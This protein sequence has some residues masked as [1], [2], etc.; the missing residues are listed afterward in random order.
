[1]EDEQYEYQKALHE[2][3][4]IQRSE[5]DRF[6]LEIGARYEK[7]LSL[8]AGGALVV[9][10][11]F[12]E[13]IAPSPLLYTRWVILPGW[14][15]LAVGV[16][17]SLIAIYQSQN[18]IQKK[19]ENLDTE[20]SQKLD[21]ENK[22]LQSIESSSNP[23]APKV[24]KANLISLY[25][26]LLGLL[27]LITFAFLNFPTEKP[28]NKNEQTIKIELAATQATGKTPACERRNLCSDKKP[29][30]PTTAEKIQIKETEQNDK[31]AKE[32]DTTPKANGDLEGVIHTESESGEP[33]KT[34]SQG[35]EEEIE[36]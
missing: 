29:S 25:S 35:S 16:I 10:L 6:A 27:F 19:I 18:A 23:H 9:S 31:S 15:L 30:S 24:R 36:G 3:Y 21:P 22:E 8:I 13:K 5:A 12:I 20:I 14:I 17:S 32:T 2:A 34:T 28:K 33:T 1:M 7:M 11:T 26:T 4:V